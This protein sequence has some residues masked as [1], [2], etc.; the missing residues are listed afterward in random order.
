MRSEGPSRQTMGKACPFPI[1]IW[2]PDPSGSRQQQPHR[3]Y[4]SR[5]GVF[6]GP[7]RPSQAG[8]VR[9]PRGRAPSG[10]TAPPEAKTPRKS[11]AATD[12]A[13]CS[14]DAPAPAGPRSPPRGCPGPAHRPPGVESR[15]RSLLPR[16][17]LPP[18]PQTTAGRGFM[19]DFRKSGVSARLGGFFWCFFFP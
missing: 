4:W 14:G 18:F 13:S 16:F 6:A 12:T 19:W 5:P 17:S 1:H 10:G 11:R 2:V 7:P 3:V 15:P 8:A 9:T